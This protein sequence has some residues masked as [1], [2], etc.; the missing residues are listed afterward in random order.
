M[1]LLDTFFAT[2]LTFLD[3]VITW[4]L[5]EKNLSARDIYRSTKGQSAV[6]PTIYLQ[7]AQET[8]RKGKVNVIKH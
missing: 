7:K 6:A 2:V 1:N 5:I 4:W 3:K 8:S